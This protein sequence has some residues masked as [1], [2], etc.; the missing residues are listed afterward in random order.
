VQRSALARI[1]ICAI[2]LSGCL[3]ERRVTGDPAG[4]AALTQQLHDLAIGEAA[5]RK[6]RLHALWASLAFA[7]AGEARLT[8]MLKHSDPTIRAWAVRAIGN[9][10]GFASFAAKANELARDANPDVKLQTA[11]SAGKRLPPA[12]RIGVLLAALETCGDDKLIPHI[13]WENLHPLLELHSEAFLD[14]VSRLDA[15]APGVAQL[16]PRAVDRILAVRPANPRALSKVFQISVGEKGGNPQIAKACLNLLSQ[17]IQSR[18]LSGDDLAAL[19]KQLD[20]PLAEMLEAKPPHPLRTEAALLAA[21][22]AHPTALELVRA[23]A[24]DGSADEGLRQLGLA[25]LA[26]AGDEKLPALVAGLLRD[27]KQNSV[28]LRGAALSSLGRLERD[29]LGE[30]VAGLYAELDGDLRPRAIELLTQRKAWGKALLAAVAGGKIPATAINVNQAQ[31]LIAF[32]DA[33]LSAAVGKHWGVVRTARDPAREQFVAQM[34]QLIRGTPGDAARGQ[35]VFGKVCGQ[36]HKIY[37]Q[38]QEVG[39]DITLNGRSSFEQLLSNVFD[40]SLVIGASYQARLIQ[41]ADGRVLTGLLVEDNAQRIVLKVQG[42]KLETIAR[43]DIEQM[44]VSELSLMPEG[45][46]K[47]LKPQE[48]ADLFAFITL[49]RPPS[50][51]QAKPIPGTREP[52]SRSTRDPKEYRALVGE[53][54]PG[55]TTDKSGEEGVGLVAEHRGRFGVLRTHPVSR[56]EPCVLYRKVDIPKDKKAKLLLAVSHDPRG[57]WR[58]TVQANGRALHDGPVDAKTAKNGWLE[59]SL[60]LSRF[61]GET[62]ELQ[63]LNQ[64]SDWSW[65][66]AYWGR[67]EIVLE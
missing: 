13:V 56:T 61:A 35:L 38:G 10:G 30:T 63:L 18:E 33:E 60:D 20:A 5:P 46:E 28:S 11:I 48:I 51:P 44:K 25:A 9:E 32:G 12:E 21:A 39:P 50:D 67:A 34:R 65:E 53:V 23:L 49:D 59:L 43:G 52:Q 57:D 54:L 16:L 17:R 27:V 4:A 2:W 31:R 64:A 6:T 14:A 36:C 37:G 55:F 19:R 58:L 22:W 29:D 45:L 26:A 3:I 1:C 24:A 41:T 15:S 7:P 47:Q 8:A 42:G 66:F 40:P 62:V